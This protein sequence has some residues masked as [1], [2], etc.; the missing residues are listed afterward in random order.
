MTSKATT[1]DE[2]LPTMFGVWRVVTR[3]SSY[4]FDLNF[5]KVTREPGPSAISTLPNRTMYLRCIEVC[6]VGELG[7][8]TVSP[9]P[10]HDPLDFYRTRSSRVV[11]IVRLDDQKPGA[12][13]VA[14]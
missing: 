5:G 8:W 2:L 3:D 12:N 10:E 6:V 9:D 14:D 1:V 11:R 4:L 7:A 13:D